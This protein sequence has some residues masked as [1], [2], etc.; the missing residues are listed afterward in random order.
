MNVSVFPLAMLSELL[1]VIGDQ[2]DECLLVEQMAIPE[3]VDEFPNHLVN[4]GDLGRVQSCELEAIPLSDRPL[5]DSVG[6]RK[7]RARR[8]MS[9]RSMR[10][11]R[12]ASSSG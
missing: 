10:T 6:S 2:D 1:A 4:V 5:R 11:T 3:P 7:R 8:R 12:R 9:S